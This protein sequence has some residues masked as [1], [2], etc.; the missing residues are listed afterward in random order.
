MSLSTATCGVDANG[1]GA[2]TV[3]PYA[4]EI[5]YETDGTT[6]AVRVTLI[7]STGI[8]T[9]QTLS[10]QF[11]ISGVGTGAGGNVTMV[12]APASGTILRIDRVLPDLQPFVVANQ[13]FYP[14]TVE[15]SADYDVMQIQQLARDFLRAIN[16]P[17]VVS[18]LPAAQANLGMRGL[19]T[20]SAVTTFGTAVTGGST[21][22][23]PV[24]SVGT[25]WT[26]G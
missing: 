17:C 22:V 24:V 18:A 26:V 3:F 23:V 25:G 15:Q 6:P 4:F 2:T 21:H 16:P 12:T 7:A 10:S 5:P 9:V 1:N 14:N 19:V 11:S 8:G 13:S 20:E